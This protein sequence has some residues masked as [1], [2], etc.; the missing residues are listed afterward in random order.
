VPKDKAVVFV[1]AS[2]GEGEPT[3]NAEVSR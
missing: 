1:M 2:Y 3:D